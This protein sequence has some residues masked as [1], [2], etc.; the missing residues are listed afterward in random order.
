MSLPGGRR[1]RARAAT[2]HRNPPQ[3]RG[4]PSSVSA[5]WLVATM[6]FGLLRCAVT[7][8]SHLATIEIEESW[9]LSLP[10]ELAPSGLALAADK[11]LVWYGA[12]SAVL[13]ASRGGSIELIRLPGTTP[14]AGRII[15]GEIEV[16]ESSPPTLVKISFSG[17]ESERMSVPLMGEIHSAAWWRGAWYLMS[18]SD[19]HLEV[20]QYRSSR[21][22]ASLLT[23]LDRAFHLSAAKDGLL[24]TAVA[25]PFEVRVVDENGHELA[26][27][28][29]PEDFS[30]C[31]R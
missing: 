20:S 23:S 24:L 19:G 15:G 6:G 25:P 16:F 8:E 2:A 26:E 10:E 14:V 27:H 9:S 4:A 11:A 7:D 22:K 28:S 18:E 5:G 12:E 1:A 13:L 29:L 17:V 3:P 31:S 21:D 30:G